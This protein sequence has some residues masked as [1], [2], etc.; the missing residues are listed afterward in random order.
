ME[1]SLSLETLLALI[2]FA[3]VMSISPGPGN[4]LLLAS[5]ANYGFPRSIPLVLGISF[6]F[7]GMVFAVG[8]G[9]GA[10]LETYPTAAQILRAACAAYVLWLAWKIARSRSLGGGSGTGLEKP[11][12]FLQAA[13]LQLLNPKAWTVALIVT[14]SYLEPE[15]GIPDLLLLIA[16]FAAVAIPS[17]SVCAL[18]GHGVRGFLA[19]G[20]RIVIFNIVMAV[21]LLASML[22][23]ILSV[24]H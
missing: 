6:G 9:L 17:I 16:V 15:A 13:S 22:P 14:V 19:R 10:V 4:F 23:A 21:L 20:N 3:F 24:A 12:T 1:S 2:G 5:G 11:F 18:S 7:L 8:L